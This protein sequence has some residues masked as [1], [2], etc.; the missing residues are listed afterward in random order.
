[1]PADKRPRVSEETIQ[2]LNDVA[3]EQFPIEP[4]G[5]AFDDKLTV[6]LDEIEEHRRLRDSVRR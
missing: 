1:M 5:I 4:S 6:L 2:H 3:A